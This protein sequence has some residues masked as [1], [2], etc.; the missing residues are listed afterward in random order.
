MP[1][2]INN[3]KITIQQNEGD[4]IANQLDEVNLHRDALGEEVDPRAV[5]G[6]IEDMPN[7]YYMTPSFIGTFFAVGIG[8]MCH[9]LGFVLPANTIT[10][11]NE[12]I[13]EC[14]LP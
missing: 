5:G 9:Y 6:S 13:G 7:G 8:T 3:D 4:A 2:D 11:I 1:E 12:D 10:V 14:S